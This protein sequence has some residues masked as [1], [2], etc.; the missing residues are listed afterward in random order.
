MNLGTIRR[1]YVEKWSDMIKERASKKEKDK[2]ENKQEEKQEDKQ[3][4]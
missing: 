3:E 1:Y 2:K 4:A